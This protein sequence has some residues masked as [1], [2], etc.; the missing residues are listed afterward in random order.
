MD[1][2]LPLYRMRQ[3][4][5]LFADRN[6]VLDQVALTTLAAADIRVSGVFAAAT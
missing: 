1:A 3:T 4:S 2:P 6:R 5:R